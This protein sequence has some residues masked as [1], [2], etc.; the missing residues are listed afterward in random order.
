MQAINTPRGQRG[1]FS[2]AVGFALLALF[3][4]VSVGIEVAHRDTEHRVA[5]ASEESELQGSQRRAE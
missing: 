1:F 4:T 3:G 2:F 5:V